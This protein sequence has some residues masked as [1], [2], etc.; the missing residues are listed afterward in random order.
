MKHFIE[1][2]ASFQ[3]F[4]G[5][6]RIKPLNQCGQWETHQFPIWTVRASRCV[7]GSLEEELYQGGI[8]KA[9]L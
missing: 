1:I 2:L 8:R 9:E 7:Y 4:K 6:F 5:S 3:F